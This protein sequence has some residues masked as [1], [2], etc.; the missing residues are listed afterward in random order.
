MVAGTGL[1]VNGRNGAGYRSR[2]GLI[3]LEAQGN[4]RYTN[5]AS[6]SSTEE[7]NFGLTLIRGTLLAVELVEESGAP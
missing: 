1:V 5:P 6:W 4:C 3:G 7:L 2:T